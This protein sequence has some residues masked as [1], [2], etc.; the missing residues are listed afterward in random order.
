VLS[1]KRLNESV[2]MMVH[3]GPGGPSPAFDHPFG[4]PLIIHHACHLWDSNEPRA[5]AQCN[6]CCML[7][8]DSAGGP[9]PAARLDGHDARCFSGSTYSRAYAERQDSRQS[10]F[11]RTVRLLIDGSSDVTSESSPLS[12]DLDSYVEHW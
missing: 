2:A 9:E 5:A 6:H 3:F 12:E 8:K 10:D 11:Q 7:K 4:C 1:V